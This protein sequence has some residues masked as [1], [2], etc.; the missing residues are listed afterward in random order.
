[1]KLTKN[2][3]KICWASAITLSIIAIG[4]AYFIN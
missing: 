2:D 3:K 1:M 4:F